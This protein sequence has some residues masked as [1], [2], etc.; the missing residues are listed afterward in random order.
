M[1]FCSTAW[2]CLD[3]YGI[4]VG[5]LLMTATVL[6]AIVA[7]FRRESIRRWWVRNRFPEVGGH[8]GG[9]AGTLDALVLIVSKPDVPR[10]L[11]R[12]LRP[13]RVSFIASPQSTA[14]AQQLDGEATAMGISVCGHSKVDNVDDP[15]PTRRAVM[16]IIAD[17]RAAGAALIAVDL[18][19]GKTPM[20]LGAFMAAEECGVQTIYVTTDFDEALSQPRMSSA[21]IVRISRPI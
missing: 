21:R 10:W 11:L 17:L 7:F 9:A 15:A 19:G 13:G 6:G 1:D 14:V 16:Q 3:R 2:E 5:D 8:L 18:T 20:S 4:V 12:Q